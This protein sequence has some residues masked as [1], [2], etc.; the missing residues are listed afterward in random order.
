MRP[1]TYFTGD[2]THPRGAGRRIIAHCCNDVG[3]WGAG[4]VMAISR[5]WSAPEEHYLAAAADYSGRMPLGSVQFVDVEPE[6]TVANIIA[7]RGFGIVPPSVPLDYQALTNGLIAVC[8]HAQRTGASVHLPRI[9]CGLAGGSWDRV[10]AL[11]EMTLCAFDVPVFVYTLPGDAAFAAESGRRGDWMQTHTGR[12]FYPLDPRAEDVCLED[13]AHALS[14]LCRYA[15]H[16]RMFYSVAQHCCLVADMLPD[17]LKL[18]GLLHDAAEA[19]LVDVPRPLKVALGD[20]KRVEHLLESVIAGVF[21][22]DFSD[23]RIKRA[24]NIALMTEARDLFDRIPAGWGVGEEPDPNHAVYPLPPVAA[25][26]RF[27][28]AFAALTDSERA[29][30]PV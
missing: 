5:R 27:L 11:I 17:E 4:V 12:M 25:K 22:V 18:A 16:C 7:Q 6:I 24:D 30:L 3:A 13:I 10:S 20:Y 9:G 26:R 1:I 2:V 8:R 14:N 28:D 19:Y 29:H 21:G 15:G 23:P